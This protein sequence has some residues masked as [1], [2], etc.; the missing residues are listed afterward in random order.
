MEEMA[1][2]FVRLLNKREDME[3]DIVAVGRERGMDV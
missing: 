1:E 3:P 2:Y